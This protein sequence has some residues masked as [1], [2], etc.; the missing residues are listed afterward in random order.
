MAGRRL[1]F[2][3]RLAVVVCK[4]ALYVFTKRTW[5]GMEHI[6]QTGGVIIVANHMSH[7]DPLVVGHFVYDAGRWPRFLAKHTLFDVPVV[8]YGLKHARQ[9]PVRRGTVDAAKALEAAVAAVRSGEAVIIYPEGTTT[10]EPHLWPMRGRTGAARLWL[11]TK[12]PVVP[13]VM[14]GPEKLYD[15]RTKKLHLRPRT[16]VEV[17]AGEPIDLSAFVNADPTP[18]NL[19]A[20]SDRIMLHLREMLIPLRPG[21][22]APPLWTKPPKVE[23]S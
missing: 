19:T 16:P 15:P 4:P 5:A 2:W 10:N 18:A 14:W 20:I 7:A 3:R 22:T 8:G 21:E 1:G 17:V 9:I 13:V 6:P 23:S 11:D 12:V